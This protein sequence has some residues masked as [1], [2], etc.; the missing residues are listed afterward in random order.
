MTSGFGETLAPR[1]DAVSVNGA[2][3]RLSEFRRASTVTSH[4][5]A[6]GFVTDRLVEL[7]VE[8][9]NPVPM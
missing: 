7:P 6:C 1:I 3:F 8:Q 4:T 5:P 9:A 2:P